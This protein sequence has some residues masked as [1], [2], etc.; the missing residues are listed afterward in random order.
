ME[1]ARKLASALLL[2][3][4]VAHLL[5]VLMAGEAAGGVGAALAGLLYFGIGIALRR[6]DVWPLWLGALL[7]A[8]GG[9]G[10]TR[11]ILASFNSV[12]LLFVLIDVVVVG[13][14][15]YLLATRRRA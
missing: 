4:G 5:H 9:L 2:F 14:C 7:P 15:V 1:P 10:G 11:L 6:P 3:T 12:T 13:C 8:L